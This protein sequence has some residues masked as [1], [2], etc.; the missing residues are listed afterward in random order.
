M[1]GRGRELQPTGLRI[2]EAAVMIA[3]TG[4]FFPGAKHDE[5][6]DVFTFRMVES[7]QKQLMGLLLVKD[8]SSIAGPRQ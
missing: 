5:I 7:N 4:E 8:T 1:H 6:H 3:R 2:I